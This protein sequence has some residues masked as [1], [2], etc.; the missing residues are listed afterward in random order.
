MHLAQ[1]MSSSKVMPWLKNL[2]KK[3]GRHRDIG[4]LPFVFVE[5]GT[6][7]FLRSW[8]V[9]AS[10][11]WRECLMRSI[12]E[13]GLRVRSRFIFEDLVGTQ[14]PPS[15]L[16]WLADVFLP[17]VG[18]RKVITNDARELL[19]HLLEVN[20]L[21]AC[22]TMFSIAFRI[23]GTAWRRKFASCCTVEIGRIAEQA[24]ERAR[25]LKEEGISRCAVSS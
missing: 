11:N 25:K 9:R 4:L 23:A 7:S 21:H 14:Q 17:L 10:M 15:P 20:K 12:P 5:M 1:E 16:R 8:R 24:L 3:R 22:K 13:K 18:A 6:D 19:R 2:N